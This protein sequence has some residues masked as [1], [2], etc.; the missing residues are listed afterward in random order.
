VAKYAVKA[1]AE[2]EG[3]KYAAKNEAAVK[4]PIIFLK[5][6]KKTSNLYYYIN[7][8][9]KYIKYINLNTRIS[10]PLIGGNKMV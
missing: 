9:A 5:H 4:M 7:I 6:A 8:T 2:I 1:E 10:H 3:I